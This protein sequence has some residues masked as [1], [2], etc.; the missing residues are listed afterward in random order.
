MPYVETREYTDGTRLR[1][2]H[3]GDGSWD[4]EGAGARP[5]TRRD[6]PLERARH[7]ADLS[8]QAEPDGPWT[9]VVDELRP[10][11][12]VPCRVGDGCRGTMTFERGLDPVTQEHSEAL[13]ARCDVSEHHVYVARG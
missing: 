4:I 8:V 7:L 11:D 10:G 5:A 6:M 3:R 9:V 12:Q 13:F 2:T 1:L